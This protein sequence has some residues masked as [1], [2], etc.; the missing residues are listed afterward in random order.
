MTNLQ[1]VCDFFA[2]VSSFLFDP[3]HIQDHIV[4]GTELVTLVIQNHLKEIK[5]NIDHFCGCVRKA[6]EPTVKEQTAIIEKNAK[7]TG[8]WLEAQFNR[9]QTAFQKECNEGISSIFS[10]CIL[11]SLIKHSPREIQSIKRDAE[12]EIEEINKQRPGTVKTIQCGSLEGVSFTH[13]REVNPESKTIVY[14]PGNATL[15]QFCISTFLDWHISTGADV[16][17]YNY[18][19]T[20][21][22]L[23]FPLN[24]DDIINDGL[25][26]IKKL[27]NEGVAPNRIFALGNTLGGGDVIGISSALEDQGISINVGN[28]R[29]FESLYVVIKRLVGKLFPFLAKPCADLASDYRWRLDS[30]A[31][32]PKLKGHL[33]VIDNKE[34][35]FIDPSISFR[36]AVDKAPS[37][38][39]R[40]LTIIDMDNQDYRREHQN[41]TARR[42]EHPHSRPLSQKEKE[43]FFGALKK[44]WG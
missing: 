1:P 6:I 23:L 42:K 7:V 18:R 27:I 12:I 8:V 19:G 13:S 41:N 17:C 22:N 32:L 11:P 39:L 38:Q 29:S 26:Q 34:D 35:D 10:L 14:F 44:I 36:S 40:S 31:S 21:G 5:A 4:P 15:W 28:D 16:I 37:L 3:E 30:A 43:A 25:I 2:D 20:G 24:E 9:I 33:V